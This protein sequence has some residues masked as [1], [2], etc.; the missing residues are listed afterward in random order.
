MPG[1][2][3]RNMK[4][5]G[6]IGGTGPES[7]VIYY[8]EL[9][10]EVYRAIGELPPLAVESLS[11]YEVLRF[12]EEGDMD[13]L[14]RYLARGVASLKAAGC[15]FAALTGITPHIVFPDLRRLSP[16]P[17]VSLV[18][19]SA[20]FI[21]K[22]GYRKVGLL[23]TG[24]TMKEPFFQDTLRSSG[25][26]VELPDKED[27]AVLA[28][29]ISSELEQGVVIMETKAWCYSLVKR[30]RDERG[31]EAAVLG[32]TELPLVFKEPGAVPFV[33][34]MRVHVKVLSG[35]IIKDRA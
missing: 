2:Y 18:E 4:K 28:Y 17:L 10:Q 9:C 27:Q 19:T 20:A 25:I 30:L 22:E 11:V 15:D 1:L 32:C 12:C 26:E 13:G 8:Q 21:R 23:G 34:V 24:P 5:L 35:M 29:K 14:C 33:D 3:L 31:I 6:L 16:L 7:T